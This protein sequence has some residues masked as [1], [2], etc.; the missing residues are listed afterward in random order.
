[1]HTEDSSIGLA[2]M[3]C[4]VLLFGTDDSDEN[5]NVSSDAGHVSP[6]VRSALSELLRN[7]L[8][9]KF[10]PSVRLFTNGRRG[11]VIR[12]RNGLLSGSWHFKR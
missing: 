2:K 6:R 5:L 1:M 8:M 7:N 10:E 3:P 9:A 4:F 12:E 11:I